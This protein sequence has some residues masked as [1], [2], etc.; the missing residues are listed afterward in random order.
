MTIPCVVVPYERLF[1]MNTQLSIEEIKLLHAHFSDSEVDEEYEPSNDEVSTENNE[2]T[3]DEFSPVKMDIVCGNNYIKENLK[4]IVTLQVICN[5]PNLPFKFDVRYGASYTLSQEP[6]GDELDRFINVICPFQIMP[7]IREFVSE[8]T[9]KGG[10]E[11][12]FIPPMNFVAM[13]K[14][15]KA[16]NSVVETKT[17]SDMGQ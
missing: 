12:L 11:P 3:D 14:Q 4:L 17:M 6:S 9:R 8:I 15:R 7:Y 13:D 5:A 2:L 1:K 16:S 10:Y